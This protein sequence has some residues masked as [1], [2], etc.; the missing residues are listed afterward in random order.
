MLVAQ[1]GERW[2]SRDKREPEQDRPC[3]SFVCLVTAHFV[4]EAFSR[5]LKGCEYH[6]SYLEF[7]KGYGEPRGESNVIDLHCRKKILSF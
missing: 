2:S 3:F 7:F 6:Q 4:P 1:D 5:A